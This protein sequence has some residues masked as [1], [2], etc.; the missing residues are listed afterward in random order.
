MPP[1]DP[2]RILITGVSGQIGSELCRS[3]LGFGTII[4]APRA[5]MDLADPDSITRAMRE[6]RPTLVIN[7]AAYT[8]VDMA[9][10]ES[11]LAMRINAEGPAVLA[12][13]CRESGALLVHYSTDYVFDGAKG[14][15]YTEEDAPNPVNVYGQS[16]L[17]GERAI[18]ASGCSHLI[19]RTCWVFNARGKNF[20]HTMLKAANKYKKLDV[21]D[22]Q[23]GTPTWARMIA[24]VTAIAL[25][26]AAPRADAGSF[27]PALSGIYHL[28]AEGYTT[29]RGFAAETIHRGAALGLCKSP[30]INAITTEQYPMLAPR[31]RDTRLDTGKLRRTFGITPPAWQTTL[32]LCLRE[33]AAP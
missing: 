32:D 31:P 16:K 22:D 15:P 6:L 21:I 4:A 18:Q 26:K 19:L 12:E 30:P 29:W 23:H 13:A 8:A 9:E 27:D 5:V 2:H 17:A 20:M 24:G 14:S 1:S 11:E 25:C 7:P 3:L 33:L 10:E 28:T